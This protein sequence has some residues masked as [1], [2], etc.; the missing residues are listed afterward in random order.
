M[1]WYRGYLLGGLLAGL[2]TPGP[3][4]AQVGDGLKADYYEGHDF[5]KLVLT[6]H[7]PAIDFSWH[8]RSPVAGVPAEDFSVRWTGWLLPPT[9]GRYV[10]H[11]SVDDGMRLWLDGRQLLND[12]RGQPLSFYQ[13]EVEL[14]AGRPYA[15]RIDYCQYGL[16]SRA[17]LAWELPSQVPPPSWRNM[18]GRVNSE[19]LTAPVPT[20]YLFSKKPA[21]RLPVAPPVAPAVPSA[22]P[23]VAKPQL[24]PTPASVLRPATPTARV[25]RHS[26]MAYVARLPQPSSAPLPIPPPAAAVRTANRLANG[27]A[28]TLRALYFEQGK[29]DLPRA[30]QASLDTLASALVLQPTLRLEVQGHTDNQGDSAINRQLSQRRAEAVCQYLTAQGVAATRLRAVGYGGTR[31]IADNRWPGL[32]PRNRRVVLVGL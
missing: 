18:W 21:S 19:A 13:V 3:V 32:R 28:V 7:D 25:V 29:A 2:L 9:T 11:L 1:N 26:A 23:V 20:R 14:Q 22:L 31:P 27:Q 12:W 8:Q 4:R 5:E 24:V 15:L 17:L 10:L 30:V 6:R 16:D